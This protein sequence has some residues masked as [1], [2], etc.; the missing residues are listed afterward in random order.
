MKRISAWVIEIGIHNFS[1]H[2]NLGL[3]T[4]MVNLTYGKIGSVLNCHTL[5]PNSNINI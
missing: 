1:T 5:I 4:P 2:Q 3:I